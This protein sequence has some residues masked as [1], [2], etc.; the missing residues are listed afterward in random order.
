[1]FMGTSQ[2]MEWRFKVGTLDSPEKCGSGTLFCFC[3]VRCVVVVMFRE[4]K[5]IKSAGLFCTFTFYFFGS[6]L[7][8]KIY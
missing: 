3:F 7:T 6:N 5:V 4:G 1:M 2:S 8:P